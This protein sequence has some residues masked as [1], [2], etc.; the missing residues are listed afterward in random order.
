MGI[1]RWV[2]EVTVK[3]FWPWFKEVAW[4][5]VRK[6]LKDLITLALEMFKERFKIWAS[7]QAKEKEEKSNQ[8]AEDFEQKANA[9]D[10]DEEAEKFR[11]IAQVWREVAEQFRQENESLRMKIDELSSEVKEQAFRKADSLEIDLD[12]SGEI[13]NLS[14]GDSIYN[15]RQLPSGDKK[16][17]G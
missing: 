12:F 4:P 3:V 9:S 1:L 7:E 8:K 15:L 10:N 13:P 17:E 11:A 5:F 14:I 2:K 6:H 16:E